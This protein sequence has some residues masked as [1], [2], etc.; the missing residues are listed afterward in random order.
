VSRIDQCFPRLNQRDIDSGFHQ[1]W[2]MWRSRFVVFAAI[3]AATACNISDS[4]VGPKA[5]DNPAA[6]ST[7][8][9]PT[10][11][12]ACNVH[13]AT[14]TNGSWFDGSKWSPAGVPGSSSSVCIDAA[15]TY[16]VTL[17]PPIDSI[18]A[19]VLAIS[20]GGAGATPTLNI[21]G[22]NGRINVTEGVAISSGATLQFS[23]TGTT[24]AA[25]GTVTNNGLLKVTAPCGG[26][27]GA[28][29][30]A[31]L[32]NTGTLQVTG[33]TK[34]T[35]SKLNG[36][37]QNTG[38]ITFGGFIDI[39]ATAGNAVFN[40]EAGLYGGAGNSETFTMRAGTFNLR[41]GKIRSRANTLPI[42]LLDGASL[43]IDSTTTDSVTIGVRGKTDAVPTITGNYPPLM[44]LWIAGAANGG[45]GTVQLIGNPVNR[46]TMRVSFFVDV[47]AGIS[48]TG[49]GRL[50]NIGTINNTDANRDT[51]FYSIDLTNTG[52]INA[53]GQSS[54]V[55]RKVGGSYENFGLIDLQAGISR[56]AIQNN[57]TFTNTSPATIT[58]GAVIV[59]ASHFR[60]T[61]SFAT[62]I[63]AQNGGSVD[64]GTSPGLL[65]VQNLNISSSGFLNIELGGLVAG[66]Q[67]DR[68][69]ATSLAAFAGTLNISEVNGFQSGLCGQVFDIA[70]VPS[71]AGG[72][73]PTINGLNP[74]TGRRLRPL[75]IGQTSTTPAILRLVGFDPDAKVCAGPDSIALSEGGPSFQYAIALR[76]A[77][78]STVIVKAVGDSQVSATD[79]AVFTTSNWQTPQ[80]LNVTAIDDAVY[81]GTHTGVVTHT[82]RSLDGTYNGVAAGSI[83][84]TITDNDS[85]PLV[86]TT[87]AV[88]IDSSSIE[89]GHTAQASAVV[90]DQNGNVMAG[91]TVVW[92]S[93][94]PSFASVS[95]NGVITAVA[96]G[97]AVI[98]A[99]DGSAFGTA[100][101]TVT[102]PPPPPPVVTSISVSIDS[103]SLQEGHTAQASATVRDQYGAVMNGQTISWSTDTPLRVSVSNAGAVTAISAG[104][105]SIRATVGS[106]SNTGSLT[107]TWPPPPPPVVTSISVS[108]DSSSLQVGHTAQATATVRDQYGAVMSGQSVTWSSNTPSLASVSSVGVVTAVGE[109]SAGIKATIGSVFG[110]ASVTIIPVPPP[111]PVVTTVSVSIDS[112]SLEVGHTAHA[113][114]T[115][116]DQYGDV[117][118]GQSVVWTSLDPTFVSVSSTG[119]ITGL[120]AT[121]AASIRA[122]VGAVNGSASI[123][124]YQLPPTVKTV[125]VTVDSA[126]MVLGNSTQATA[127]A[128][129]AAKNAIAGLPVT[130]TSL[131]PAIATVS[132]S[133]V[134]TGIAPGTAEIQATIAGV[135]GSAKLRVYILES[136]FVSPRTFAFGGFPFCYYIANLNKVSMSLAPR[137]GGFAK[138]TAVLTEREAYNSG[139]GK[140]P[141]GLQ[142]HYTPTKNK[143]I[144]FEATSVVIEDSGPNASV[145]VELVSVPG[146]DKTIAATLN[147]YWQKVTVNGVPY[148]R[149]YVFGDLTFRH[150]DS[151]PQLSWETLPVHVVFF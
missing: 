120:Q 140:C 75:Y 141:A 133:G 12:T 63:V 59:D 112:T 121:L 6:R 28:T 31:D 93:N 87:V 25:A 79:S 49:S 52:T 148:P 97:T 1:G 70:H 84:A 131:T 107:I 10:S 7:V 143:L 98:K 47:F 124:I 139:E 151:S 81:E 41:G 78:T 53:V 105:A 82:V 69:V 116:R 126:E 57:A 17:D 48:V 73:F 67:Y 8:I 35:L 144:E 38:N 50:T 4:T 39:P 65:T 138:L 24:L 37:Y 42:V 128:I 127:T 91:E 44:T 106:V 86:P 5:L 147:G 68:V 34:L 74:G 60:G 95:A 113:T 108:I 71:F 110:N 36:Q 99:T 89:V 117:M 134:V 11:N 80:I 115:V 132:A 90:R 32:I 30:S 33:G 45:N 13:W 125:A 72:Q 130:W 136:H 118:A 55:L 62:Q 103:A 16:T 54:I 122:S 43:I 149:V 88:T 114:A 64:P 9:P 14:G 2:F 111:S 123:I 29:I 77:P 21:A 20:V 76:D 150:I 46:G 96:A 15:G 94:T 92:S 135:T 109:G 27:G 40:Q 137:N 102:V 119:V 101:V 104:S 26:C 23:G 100:S 19:P 58:N 61:G 142:N 18:P 22:D 66:T 83:T 129:D 146:S 145:R 85:P 3:A 56:L 51:L